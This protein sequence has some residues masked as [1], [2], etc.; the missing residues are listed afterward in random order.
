MIDTK[1]NT[2][3]Y[4]SQILSST[5]FFFHFLRG[6]GDSVHN[7]LD[8]AKTF[9]NRLQKCQTKH[10]KK[11]NINYHTLFAVNPSKYAR[12]PP[13]SVVAITIFAFALQKIDH[14]LSVAYKNTGYVKDNP[15]PYRNY[16]FATLMYHKY[17]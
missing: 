1:G 9:C 7:Q 12:C 16:I 10:M 14:I 3:D 17:L 15:I 8:F 2:R 5:F 13:C 6:G 11:D 4:Q